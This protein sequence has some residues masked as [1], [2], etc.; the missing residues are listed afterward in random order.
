MNNNINQLYPI[1]EFFQEDDP[2]ICE[3]QRIVYPESPVYADPVLAQRFWHW[4][5]WDMPWKKSRIFG[6]AAHGAILGV[7][8]LSF[9]PVV[10]DGQEILCG[11]LNATVTHPGYRKLGIFSRTLTHTLQVAE[12]EEQV[13]FA[14]SFPNDNS[15]PLHLKNPKMSALCD[16]PLYVK[17]YNPQIVQKKI[18]VPIPLVRIGLACLQKT[19]RYACPE[20]IRVSE[21]SYFDSRFDD[22]WERVKHYHRVWI[23]RTSRYLNWRYTKSPLGG[24][25]IFA[26]V[27]GEEKIVGYTVVKIESHFGMRTG[28]FLDLVTEQG[29]ANLPEGLVAAGL[30]WCKEQGADAS[31][32]LMLPHHRYVSALRAHG[33]VRVFDKLAPRKFHVTIARLGREQR[34]HEHV[35]DPRNWYLTWGDT[36]NV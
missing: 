26:A 29:Y 28:L 12:Q 8:P 5:F 11:V 21:I 22:L 35:C 7:R 20:G 6:V 17:L 25:Q 15:Y 36:D 31:G 34:L 10:V 24:Y 3:L 2:R 33:M 9:L 23:A 1:I 27:H 18:P 19:K 30:T 4:W 32:C 14:I 13:G 16:L